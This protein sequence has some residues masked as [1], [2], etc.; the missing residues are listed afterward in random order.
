M[1]T[2]PAGDSPVGDEPDKAA[3]E[4][5]IRELEAIGETAAARSLREMA[6]EQ[7]ERAADAR[8]KALERAARA[9]I[10]SL[11]DEPW[12]EA[13]LARDSWACSPGDTEGSSLLARALQSEQWYPAVLFAR[14]RGTAGR[15]PSPTLIVA[16]WDAD[17]ACFVFCHGGEQPVV[18]PVDELTTLRLRNQWKRYATGDLLRDFRLRLSSTQVEV[19]RHASDGVTIGPRAI[20]KLSLGKRRRMRT[21]RAD[22]FTGLV[23]RYLIDVEGKITPV[24]RHVFELIAR[25]ASVRPLYNE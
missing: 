25:G 11:E 7:V 2:S 18:V 22:T 8:I 6:T 10:R 16:G 9:E 15:E 20:G 14:R 13:V 21:L 19:L 3:L 12:R 5:A 24:G 23:R 4:R 17:E 1:T